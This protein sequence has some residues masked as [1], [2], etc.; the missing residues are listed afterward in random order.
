[1]A[2]GLKTLKRILRVRIYEAGGVRALSRETGTNHSHISEAL[3]PD[4]EP[5]PSIV[6][7]LG[8]RK[9][10]SKYEEIT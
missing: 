9:A 6:E 4:V 1:M 7:M 3:K 2:I 8:Y 5:I 10:E